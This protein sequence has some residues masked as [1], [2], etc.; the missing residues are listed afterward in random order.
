MSKK[1][2]HEHYIES[3]PKY[4]VDINNPANGYGGS[5]V[6]KQY[7]WTDQDEK[8]CIAYDENGKLKFHAD[9]DIEIIAG[10][11][12]PAGGV[13]ILIHS[14]KGNIEIHA[15]ENG[16]LR[17]SGKNISIRADKSMLI[18]G[19][20]K[21]TMEANDIEF[22]GNTIRGNE[23]YGNMAPLRFLSG[24]YKGLK[25]GADAVLAAQGKVVSK[26]K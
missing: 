22:K 11:L 6:F 15:D 17:L 19:G 1:T 10:A 16:E 24:V 18:D 7:A 8:A 3:Y 4:R 20:D 23:I 12:K 14:C 26:F 9:K 25:V 2:E 21:I 5:N 13:D